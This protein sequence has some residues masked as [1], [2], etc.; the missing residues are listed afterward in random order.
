MHAF[1]LDQFSMLLWTCWNHSSNTR[2]IE[3]EKR[4]TFDIFWCLVGMPLCWVLF[5]EEKESGRE[6]EGEI[7]G[8]TPT[9]PVWNRLQ[10]LP[11]QFTP[12]PETLCG[13]GELVIMWIKRMHKNNCTTC[14]ALMLM[15]WV[16][17]DLLWCE[18][19]QHVTSL[20]LLIAVCI[21]TVLAFIW[22]CSSLCLMLLV[23]SLD[24]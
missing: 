18:L 22:I 16:K 19:E 13:E 2:Q 12:I 23:M 24:L 4:K 7:S 10:L 14:Y 6:C 21:I 15:V 9:D 20:W 11:L 17:A 3:M 1:E 5:R 8:A